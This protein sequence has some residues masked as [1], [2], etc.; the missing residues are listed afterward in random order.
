[1]KQSA[2]RKKL[3]AGRT[4]QKIHLPEL[5]FNQTAAKVKIRS[6]S[7]VRI[8]HSASEIFYIESQNR[9]RRSSR[10]RCDSAI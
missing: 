8:F 2:E 4:R 5:F 10:K 6:P 9:Q 7:D 1:L 3:I